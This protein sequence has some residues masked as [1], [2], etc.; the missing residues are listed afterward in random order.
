MDCA[1]NRTGF[2]HNAREIYNPDAM[3]RATKM[4]TLQMGKSQI[5]AGEAG[6][7]QTLEF[8]MK[9]ISEDTWMKM[10]WDMFASHRQ[11]GYITE[12]ECGVCARS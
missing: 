1:D 11:A 5:G 4:G 3:S 2:I 12:S 7:K 8:R 6:R 10:V 9:V